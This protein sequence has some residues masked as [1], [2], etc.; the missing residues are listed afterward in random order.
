MSFD[1]NKNAREK[2][3]EMLN[4]F[5]K[6][7]YNLFY[8]HLTTRVAFLLMA[9]PNAFVA[10][11]QYVPESESRLPCDASKN[12]SDPSGR[13]AL[14]TL[15]AAST[16]RPSLY[17]RISGCGCPSDLQFNVAGSCSSTAVSVGCS[18]IRG[19][20]PQNTSKKR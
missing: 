8:L 4:G 3:R 18:T 19:A 7:Y 2:Q 11:H 17:H 1:V 14:R 10:I 6:K 5:S 15:L 20:R 16:G 9:S 12:S 13:R